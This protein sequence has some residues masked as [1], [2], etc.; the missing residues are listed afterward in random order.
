MEAPEEWTVQFFSGEQQEY[1]HDELFAADALL[2]GRKT[3]QIFADSWPE[4]SNEDDFTARM[5]TIPKYVVSGS[6]EEAE[7]NNSTIINENVANEISKLKQQSGQNILV[8]GSA[9]LVNTLAQHD[10]IDEYRLMVFPIVLGNGKRLFKEKNDTMNL[11]LTETK[12]F[13]SGVVVLTYQPQK[14]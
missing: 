9:E 8:A 14:E 13:D 4:R 5:N 7:W 10:L 2:L 1:K 3:Y 12:I 11:E 6:L